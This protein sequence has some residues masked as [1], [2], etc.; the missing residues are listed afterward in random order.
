MATAFMFHFGDV[1]K[2]EHLI[3]YKLNFFLFFIASF[4]RAIG[5]GCAG[6]TWFSSPP[7]SSP[8]AHIEVFVGGDALP[9]GGTH[10]GFCGGYRLPQS[11]GRGRWHDD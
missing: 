3:F 11:A 6:F 2:D 7:A 1:F 10:Q 4:S 5:M 9:V 8:T